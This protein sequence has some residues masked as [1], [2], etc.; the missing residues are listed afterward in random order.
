MYKNIYLYTM[1]KLL[2]LGNPLLLI[3]YNTLVCNS[4]LKYFSK[5]LLFISTSNYNIININKKLTSYSLNNLVPIEV[6]IK[7]SITSGKPI[8]F[9]PIDDVKSDT[10]LINIYLNN[11]KPLTN[12]EFL[13]N[14]RKFR[15]IKKSVI[16]SYNPSLLICINLFKNFKLISNVKNLGIPSIGL[17]DKTIVNHPFEISICVPELSSH[18]QTYYFFLIFKLIVYYKKLLAKLLIYNYTNFKLSYLKKL[19]LLK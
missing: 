3:N 9:L 6:T 11:F 18:F 10:N 5:T 12:I 2:N 17:V 7:N 13:L 1:L 8:Y 14:M 4:H 16:S 19:W 15:N